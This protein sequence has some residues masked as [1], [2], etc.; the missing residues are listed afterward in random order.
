MPEE[1][2][3]SFLFPD[4]QASQ[5]SNSTP[6][7]KQYFEIKKQHPD[8]L[9]LFR[10][11]DFYEFFYDDART[12]S[13]ELNLTLTS[14][15]NDIPM[16]G[17][18]YHAAD[19]YIAKLVQKG[20]KLVICDQVEDP[21][22]AKALV[23]REVTSIITPGTVTNLL[24]LDDRRNNWLLTIGSDATTFTACFADISTGDIFVSACHSVERRDFLDNLLSRFGTRE[25]LCSPAVFADPD[26][27]KVL[28]QHNA[29]A[30]VTEFPA[31]KFAPDYGREKLTSQYKLQN[32]QSLGLEDRPDLVSVA[33]AA[34]SYMEETQKQAL[35]GLKK[36]RYFSISDSMYLDRATI[37]N[38]E[39]TANSQDGSLHGSLLSVVDLT[40]T[41]V[42]AR[43]LRSR[44]LQPLL[45]PVRINKR[46]DRVSHF[47]EDSL[48]R[49]EVRTI[50]REINDLERLATR[51]ALK[52]ANPKEVLALR[53][54]LVGARKLLD[55]LQQTKFYKSPDTSELVAMIVS[56]L[57]DDPP[58][59]I[60]DGGVVR[61]GFDAELDKY[62]ESQTKGRQW[63]L[64]LEEAERRRTHISSLKVRFNNV[65][66]YY[67]EVTKTNL[68][69]V[70][71][72]YIRKQTL[73]NAERFTNQ[74][75]QEYE[76]LIL[77]AEDKVVGLEKKIFDG[78]L[79]RIAE[80]TALI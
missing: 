58:I 78:L 62:R 9:L 45:D 19:N 53:N 64:D 14:R 42:G 24:M 13:R 71:Q 4:L 49:G 54:S 16:C 57:S 68:P 46:L 34:L 51:V 44:L 10:L 67:I 5:F 80:K 2:P 33:G 23:K 31:W 72:D 41:S 59:K 40:L 65:F 12:A 29:D 47:V 20:I 74:K 61:P 35:A 55:L 6:M 75:L 76:T 70:P 27:K 1:Q 21:K 60:E 11:G 38:L 22:L 39:L 43:L 48:L 56:C 52:K 7:M 15:H 8:K 30:A 79:D 25:V 73:A 37:R 36:V 28:K 26:V 63:I 66:G 3:Q 32:L 50:L 69:L 18:P 17:I 77:S